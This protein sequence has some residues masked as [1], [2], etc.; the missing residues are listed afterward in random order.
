M[1]KLLTLLIAISFLMSCSTPT[2]GPDKTIGGAVL[3]AAWGAGAGAVVGNQL[4][5][6]RA[7]EGTAIG[8][9]FGLVSGA[10]T[11]LMY[12]SIEDKHLKLSK[13]LGSLRR[14][15]IANGNRLASLQSKVDNGSP[16]EVQAG[17]YQVFFDTDQTN[18]RF[19]A[20]KNL[21]DYADLLR[22]TP[23]RY[24]I[25]V[26]GHTD[27]TG[28]DQYNDRLALDRAKTVGSYLMARGLNVSDFSVTSMGAKNP[29]ATNKTPQGRQL[30]RRVDVY[31]NKN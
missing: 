15:N 3:G 10:L 9:G 26:V 25:R 4:I 6:D 30:N 20:I 16:Q 23:S 5:P 21:Q 8:A 22:K 11:G 12:D 28:N 24:N 13:K 27:D 2:P 7:G 17:V 19:G 1:K 18:L 29:I 31:L 14:Q